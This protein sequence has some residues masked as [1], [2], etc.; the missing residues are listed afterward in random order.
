MLVPV[1]TGMIVVVVTE[2][3][4]PVQAVTIRRRAAL[5]KSLTVIATF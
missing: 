3:V 2:N 4:A 1:V 5:D